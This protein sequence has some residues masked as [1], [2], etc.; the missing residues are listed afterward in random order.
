MISNTRLESFDLRLETVSLQRGLESRGWP[1]SWPSSSCLWPSS[2]LQVQTPEK[3]RPASGRRSPASTL[4]SSTGTRTGTRGWRT[5]RRSAQSTTFAS[6]TRSSPSSAL[7][8]SSLTSG[9][10]FVIELTRYRTMSVTKITVDNSRLSHT[11][12]L[13]RSPKETN[14]PEHLT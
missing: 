13:A 10:R 2:C 1:T 3:L 6:R 14:P 8:G 5:G 7:L 4:A 11:F 9:D 12:H